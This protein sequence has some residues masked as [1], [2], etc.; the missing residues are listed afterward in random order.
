MS[1]RPT[2]ANLAEIH[3][4][5]DGATDEAYRL[6]GTYCP[7]LPLMWDLNRVLKFH[8]VE[9]IETENTEEY[10]DYLNAGDCYIRTIV[11]FRGVLRVITV[12]DFFEIARVKFR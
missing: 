5:G 4:E 10:A 11:L 6:I 12:A 2:R 7:G 3:N 9:A 8:G 1:F